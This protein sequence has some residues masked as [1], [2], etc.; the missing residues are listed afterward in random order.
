MTAHNMSAGVCGVGVVEG[1]VVMV[2]GYGSWSWSIRSLDDV[3]FGLKQDLDLCGPHPDGMDIRRETPTDSYVRHIAL[4]SIIMAGRFE[5]AGNR[6]FHLHVAEQRYGGR[7]PLGLIE[8]TRWIHVMID[9]SVHC[10]LPIFV[11]CCWSISLLT[12]PLHTS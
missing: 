7:R 3:I 12:E 8:E 9:S 5:M 1:I 10:L 11:Y 2:Y 4:I 6:T